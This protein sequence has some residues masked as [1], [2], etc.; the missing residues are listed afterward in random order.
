VIG[1][2][3]LLYHRFALSLRHVAELMLAR[4]V[5]SGATDRS[6]QTLM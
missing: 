1:H 5:V 4:G 2:A 6:G 3:V